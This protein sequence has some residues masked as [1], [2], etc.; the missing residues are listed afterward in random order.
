MPQTTGLPSAPLLLLRGT[1]THVSRRLLLK[2]GWLTQAGF[3]LSGA[4]S[5]RIILGVEGRLSPSWVMRTNL[6]SVSGSRLLL[7]IGLSL[8]F[9]SCGSGGGSPPPPPPPPYL[10]LSASPSTVNISP[11]DSFSTTVTASTNTS[12]TPTLASVQLPSGITTTTT[13][14]VTIPASGATINFQ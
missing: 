6:I 12:S 9:S 11:G 10:S 4:K 1:R 8:L 5:R 3:G 14:P 13:L 7:A 2:D